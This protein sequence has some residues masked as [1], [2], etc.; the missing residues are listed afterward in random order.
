M[1]KIHKLPKIQK[2]S[3]LGGGGAWAGNDLD[4]R[5]LYHTIFIRKIVLYRIISLQ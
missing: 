4:K 3:M 2:S 5:I 1:P